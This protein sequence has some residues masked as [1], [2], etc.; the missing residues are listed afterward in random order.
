MTQFEGRNLNLVTI[1]TPVRDDYQLTN[2]AQQRVNHINIYDSKDP[3]QVSEGNSIVILP[4]NKSNIKLTG[5]FGS[6]RRTFPNA[7][8]I[9][10]DNPVG[11]SNILKW[12]SSFGDMHNSHNR[13]DDL[14][15]ET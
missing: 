11:I 10:V 3:V 9:S 5:E 15:T 7:Q 12:Q 2:Q 13:P 1:N 4:Q 8:N 14:K 6:A